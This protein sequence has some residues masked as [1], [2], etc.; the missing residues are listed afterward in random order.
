[1]HC[2]WELS[3]YTTYN[4]ATQSNTKGKIAFVLKSQIKVR[5]FW[6]SI[7]NWIAIKSMPI[8]L[9]CKICKGLKAWTSWESWQLIDP[10]VLA[11]GGVLS[12]ANEPLL[13]CH[14][15]VGCHQTKSDDATTLPSFH[16]TTIKHPTRKQPKW[17]ELFSRVGKARKDIQETPRTEKLMKSCFRAFLCKC[18]IQVVIM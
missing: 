16:P 13:P 8:R 2:T 10:R 9:I 11:Q 6:R 18:A 17:T 12:P 15:Q 14:T 7:P 3:P 5:Y 1:M 4:P